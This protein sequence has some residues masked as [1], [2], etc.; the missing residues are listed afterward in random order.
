VLALPRAG[1][2]VGGGPGRNGNEG[3]RPLETQRSNPPPPL[4]GEPLSSGSRD[5]P[6]G[7][8]QGGRRF[9]R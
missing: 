1:G 6:R 2:P 8:G 4:A 9:L 7:Q 3:T 5:F